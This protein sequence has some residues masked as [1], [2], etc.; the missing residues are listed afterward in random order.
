MPP[1][2]LIPPGNC[3]LNTFAALGGPLAFARCGASP[4]EQH[5]NL[6]VARRGPSPRLHRPKGDGRDG[7]TDAFQ[8]ESPVPYL[9]IIKDIRERYRIGERKMK[10]DQEPFVGSKEGGRKDSAPEC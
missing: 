8:M 2:L 4:A 1:P 5:R 3:P 10:K 7:V 6:L 9:A